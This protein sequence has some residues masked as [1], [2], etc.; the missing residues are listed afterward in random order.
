MVYMGIEEYNKVPDKVVDNKVFHRLDNNQK[1][2]KE[3]SLHV[4]GV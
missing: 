2:E 3:N 1:V 4:P